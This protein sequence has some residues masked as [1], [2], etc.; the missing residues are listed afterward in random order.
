MEI[1]IDGG[2]FELFI[3]VAFGYAVNFI[4]LKKYLLLIF[5]V[6]AIAAPVVLF[7]FNT[8]ELH[9]WMA[10]LCFFNAIILT[11]LAWKHRLNFPG[12]PLVDTEKLKS[13]FNISWFKN[14]VTKIKEN[15]IG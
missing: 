4:F 2:L 5:S 1:F 9:N 8:G 15:I 3:A 12:K 13:K 6:L 11:V 7:F 10:G 14:R